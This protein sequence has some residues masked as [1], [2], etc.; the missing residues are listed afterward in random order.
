[1]KSASS[2]V[3]E[4]PRPLKD[5]TDSCS[6]AIE[7]VITTPRDNVTMSDVEGSYMRDINMDL[8]PLVAAMQREETLR[9]RFSPNLILMDINEVCVTAVDLIGETF[10]A[11][12]YVRFVRFT[13]A[14]VE[15]GLLLGNDK[16]TKVTG[17]TQHSQSYDY[18]CPADGLGDLLRNSFGISIDLTKA[19]KSSDVSVLS[20]RHYVNGCHV[21]S[22]APVQQ[23]DL[24]IRG[25]F[26]QTMALKMFPFDCQQLNMMFEIRLHDPSI[27][28]V[29][30]DGARRLA[31]RLLPGYFFCE[32][33]LLINARKRNVRKVTVTSVAKRRY[34]YY[35]VNFYSQIFA[36]TTAF[37]LVL[38]IDASSVA[39]RLGFLVTL[40][41]AAAALQI[42]ILGSLPELPYVTMLNA[43]VVFSFSLMI[44]AMVCNS[45]AVT[46]GDTFDMVSNVALMC[47]WGLF[48]ICHFWKAYSV[49]RFV[50]SRLGKGVPWV[51]IGG[52]ERVKAIKMSLAGNIDSRFADLAAL[53]KLMRP[54]TL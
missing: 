50:S 9:A 45:L 11:Q 25:T 24:T 30:F 46:F 53:Q 19:N 35:V 7:R 5:A 40:V 14:T 51:D 10:E 29:Q 39:E 21:I 48:N 2:L 34:R 36:L 28:L 3:V 18:E 6:A 43:Y 37:I 20:A 26:K 38:A 27:H 13:E 22:P 8:G 31:Y 15:S 32:P 49:M 17:G 41:L 23:I 47:L 52:T 33:L 16:N 44:A 1:M 4:P 12:F 54:E 42:S